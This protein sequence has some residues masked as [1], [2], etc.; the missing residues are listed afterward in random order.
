[1]GSFAN[2]LYS[3]AVPKSLKILDRKRIAVQI[4]S[5][6][7]KVKPGIILKKCRVLDI[8][9]G[10]GAI[11]FYISPFVKEII[12]LDEDRFAIKDGK[13]SIIGQIYY[14]SAAKLKK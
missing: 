2:T 1:M 5:C 7:K 10:N 8:A 3:E 12:A 13:K 6:I 14:S 4:I 11:S 9:A